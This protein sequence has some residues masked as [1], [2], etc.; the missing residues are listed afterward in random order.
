MLSLANE[1]YNFPYSKKPYFIPVHKRH[2]HKIIGYTTQVLVCNRLRREGTETQSILN[3]IT[4]KYKLFKVRY[5]I[6]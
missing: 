5:T 6:F 1:Y 4:D 3:R 2:N